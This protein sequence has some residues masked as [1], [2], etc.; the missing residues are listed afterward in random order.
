M[1]RELTYREKQQSRKL[2]EQ[3]FVED[4]KEFLDYYYGEKWKDNVILGSFQ[5]EILV[6]MLQLNPYKLCLGN[7]TCISDYIVAV[8]TKEEYRHQGRMTR[9]LQQSLHKAREQ[10]CPFVFLMPAKEAIYRPFDFVTVYGRKDYRINREMLEEAMSN[11]QKGMAV[12]SIYIEEITEA[13]SQ[14]KKEA[15]L[16]ELIKYSQSELQKRYQLFAKRDK[17]YYTRLLKE[18]CSQQGGIFLAKFCDTDELCG[19]CFFTKEEELQLRELVCDDTVEIE[20]LKTI[21]ENYGSLKEVKLFGGEFREDTLP[22]N[23]VFPCI[24]VRIT[25][26]TGLAEL[27]SLTAEEKQW[28]ENHPLIEIVDSY[29]E[30][31]QGKYTLSVQKRGENYFVRA[32]KLQNAKE[33][34]KNIPVFTIEEIT[35]KTFQN[36]KIFLNEIV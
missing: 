36:L 3:I 8:A 15:A 25:D 12:S 33:T 18:Q 5:D 20:I 35:R 17:A 1:E 29:F 9:L 22:V 30:E 26:V 7:A 6:S 23:T 31:N 28:I 27:I 19:Y 13:T 11:R 34:E 14:Q 4:T 2:W 24:M 10:G 16:A 21:L 32:E